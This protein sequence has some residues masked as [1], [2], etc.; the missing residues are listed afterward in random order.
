MRNIFKIDLYSLNSLPLRFL[1]KYI[2]KENDNVDGNLL[3]LGVYGGRS[4]IK[5]AVILKR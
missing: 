2:I 5:I 3:D 4:M 1:Y